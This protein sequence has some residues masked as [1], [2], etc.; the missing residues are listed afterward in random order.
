MSV[1]NV[2]AN[3][4]PVPVPV[5]TE[6]AF[7]ALGARHVA[8]GMNNEAYIYRLPEGGAPAV[9]ACMPRMPCTRLIFFSTRTFAHEPA[10]SLLF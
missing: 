1:I 8:A 9:R 10:L 2:A 5:E 6:P 7:L 3:G 4:D